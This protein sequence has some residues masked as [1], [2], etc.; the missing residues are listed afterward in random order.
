MEGGVRGDRSTIAALDAHGLRLLHRQAAASRRMH[1]HA[2]HSVV[3][4]KLRRCTTR[5]I[6]R[7]RRDDIA[8]ALVCALPRCLHIHRHVGRHRP[9][10]SSLF[11]RCR[12]STTVAEH[13][14]G[15]R[16]RVISGDHAAGQAAAR[17]AGGLGFVVVCIGMH[18]HRVAGDIEL[19]GLAE[20]DVAGDRAVDAGVTLRV[21]GDVGHVA[22]VV[23]VGADIAVIGLGRV[24]V[25]AGA[26][27]VRC[28]AIALLVDVEA[29]LGIGLEAAE[30]AGDTQRTVDGLERH[31]AFDVI[32]LGRLE[33]GGCG[34][35]G[36]CFGDHGSGVF[37]TVRRFGRRAG[38]RCRC[39]L[40]RRRF[41]ALA[42]GQHQGGGQKQGGRNNTHGELLK[43]GRNCSR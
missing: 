19:V 25:T 38:L 8:T 32:T 6:K 7:Q 27:A 24:E 18:D 13:L 20:V 36:C 43:K 2:R 31:R 37:A 9:Q 12:A 30:L 15:R 40:G 10:R 17:V 39:R 1:P 28:A 41:V 3:G 21:G 22:T 29:V 14:L 42:R 26:A 35:G 5:L 23:R 11:N 16:L 34:G 4:P 33:L